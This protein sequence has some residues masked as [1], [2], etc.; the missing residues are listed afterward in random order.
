LKIWS[1]KEEEED[2]SADW[3]KVEEDVVE[4]VVVVC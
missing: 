1:K 2:V 3:S 4:E